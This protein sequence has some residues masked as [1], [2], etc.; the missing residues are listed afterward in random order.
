MV[1]QP[2]LIDT[3][4]AKSRGRFARVCIE[5]D[6]EKPLVAT[7]K[8]KGKYWKLQ[9]E[10]LHELCFVCGKYGHT[11]PRCPKKTG[12]QVVEVD[13]LTKK[14]DN[15]GECFSSSEPTNCSPWMVAQRS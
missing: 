4:L 7:Y 2:E 11:D 1:R 14:E 15:R 3:T 8:M 12:K 9:Y 10:G 13:E 5:I 6:L